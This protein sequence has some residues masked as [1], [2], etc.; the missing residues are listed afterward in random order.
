MP[1]SSPQITPHH[2]EAEVVLWRFVSTVVVM[3]LTL[4]LGWLLA[5]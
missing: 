5:Q 2:E 4:G 1:I 3:L